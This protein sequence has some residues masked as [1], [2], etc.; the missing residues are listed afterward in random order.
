MIFEWSDHQEENTVSSTKEKMDEITEPVRPIR[1][2]GVPGNPN[3]S[4]STT[5]I[6]LIFYVFPLKL[7]HFVLFI[8]SNSVRRIFFSSATYM[9]K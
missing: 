3:L 5:T 4:N 1:G 2:G 8:F 6:T 9:Y 7:G